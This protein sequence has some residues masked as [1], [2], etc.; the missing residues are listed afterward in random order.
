[1]TVLGAAGPSPSVPLVARVAAPPAPP[2]AGTARFVGDESAYWRLMVRGAVLLMVTLGIYRFWLA[3]DQRRFLWANTEIAGD[4]LE[5]TGTARELLI[6]FLVAVAVL[7]PLYAVLSLAALGF[8]V[9]V[10]FSGLLGFRLLWLSG[11][12]AI[13]R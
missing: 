6:G 10:E 4:A 11:T 2:A 3:T 1:M 7:V 13:F 12:F 8:G 9:V 5:Y